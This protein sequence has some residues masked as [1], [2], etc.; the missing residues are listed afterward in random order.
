MNNLK[1]TQ[2]FNL[3]SKTNLQHIK[4]LFNKINKTVNNFVSLICPSIIRFKAQ[5]KQKLYPLQKK[6]KLIK[7]KKCFK[8]AE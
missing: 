7:Y 8:N 6:P 2:K 4:K 5:I 1:E 3:N